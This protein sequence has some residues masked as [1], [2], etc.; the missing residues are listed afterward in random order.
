[1]TDA[2]HAFCRANGCLFAPAGEVFTRIL[3]HEPAETL[4]REDGNHATPV[5]VILPP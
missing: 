1:M 3:L 2:Y 4:Y 5:A